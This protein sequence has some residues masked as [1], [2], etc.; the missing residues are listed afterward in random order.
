MAEFSGKHK[1]RLEE[2]ERS[3]EYKLARTTTSIA[4]RV[5]ERLAEL[6]M[7]RSDLA[8]RLGVDKSAVTQI[9]SGG[10]NPKLSTLIRLAEALGL[11]LE[12]GMV[13]PSSGRQAEPSH[14]GLGLLPSGEPKRRMG[15]STMTISDSALIH[16]R[17][18]GPWS[19]V[20]VT[21]T[22]ESFP[23]ESVSDELRQEEVCE[24]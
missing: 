4:L 21:D 9:L 14:G 19:L 5:N 1:S 17:G 24:L 23:E 13:K 20:D 3:W 6:E 18:F 15:W 12:I 16:Q 22:S 8:E 10:N 11:D 2:V 7:T